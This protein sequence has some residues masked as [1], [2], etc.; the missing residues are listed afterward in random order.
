MSRHMLDGAR[1]MLLKTRLACASMFFQHDAEAC[2]I[3]MRKEARAF[4]VTVVAGNNQ[5]DAAPRTPGLCQADDI[6]G[7]WRGHDHWDGNNVLL[8]RA[9]SMTTIGGTDAAWDPAQQE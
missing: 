2:V 8:R 9:S 5:L 6:V 7:K 3:A 1:S 4:A